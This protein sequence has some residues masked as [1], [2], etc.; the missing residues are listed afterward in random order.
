MISWLKGQIIQNWH[1]SSKKGVVINVGGIGYEVQLLSRQISTIDNS[2]DIA[3]LE[4]E[5]LET[6]SK[7]THAEEQLLT[8][9][10]SSSILN[11]EELNLDDSSNEEETLPSFKV[12]DDMFKDL[13]DI[14]FIGS[15]I[16]WN[17]NTFN[18]K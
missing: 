6:I 13:D 18:F 7:D 16:G 2:N 9:Y 5:S 8:D 15:W 11:V 4:G 1:L 10:L 14:K 3:S 12:I 17:S